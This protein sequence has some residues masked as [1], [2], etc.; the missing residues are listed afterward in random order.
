MQTDGPTTLEPGQVRKISLSLTRGG[1]VE[2]VI[3]SLIPDWNGFSGQ[4]RLP[5]QDAV[6]VSI[7]AA[8]SGGPYA[9]GQM[10]AS[11]AFSQELPP[12]SGMVSVFNFATSP[13]MMVALRVKHPA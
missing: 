3:Q 10:G 2:V 12:G 5:G 4:R 13:R 6:F 1:Q 7:C 9:N 8:G 11:D